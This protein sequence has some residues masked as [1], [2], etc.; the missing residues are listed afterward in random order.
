MEWNP[1]EALLFSGLQGPGV[2]MHNGIQPR[3][4]IKRKR[5]CGK[6]LAPISKPGE[7][8][9]ENP[10]FSLI[11]AWEDDPEH[12]SFFRGGSGEIPQIPHIGVP[13]LLHS[14]I[15][16]DTFIPSFL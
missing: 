4:G 13:V 10:H 2:K 7:K 11:R 14:G 1:V 9:R 12:S 16:A 15:L 5:P 8:K 3:L 6:F